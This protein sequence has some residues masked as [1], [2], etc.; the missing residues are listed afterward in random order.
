MWQDILSDLYFT[1][2]C[3]RMDHWSDW[4]N[5][6]YKELSPRLK[7]ARRVFLGA[8]VIWFFEFQQMISKSLLEGVSSFWPLVVLYFNSH[9]DHFRLP[10]QSIWLMGWMA[11]AGF[12][13][14]SLVTMGIVSVSFSQ[15]PISFWLWRFL[16][17]VMAI[18]GF[19]P[20]IIIQ[21]FLYLGDTGP[22][23]LDL[24][25]RCLS[26]QG[27]KM[28]RLLQLLRRWLSWEFP[29]RIPFSDCSSD[30]L[31][32]VPHAPDRNHLH[33][34]LLSFGINAS[35]NC[36]GYHGFRWFCY[37]FSSI[38]YFDSY[39]WRSAVIGLVLGVGLLA[40]LIGV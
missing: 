37:D 13:L 16:S 5:R 12:R 36:L 18:T 34:R 27:L 11:S 38:E 31:V 4:F 17:W 24:C 14:F 1:S 35:W 10:M 30:S 7:D 22:S 20:L 15:C 21:R 9:L 19:F 28:R 26:L 32:E 23:S 33:H 8:S 40:E 3:W 2:C 29:L 39:W 25:S 6:W